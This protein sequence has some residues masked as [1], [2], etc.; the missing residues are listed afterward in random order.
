MLRRLPRAAG[1]G[2]FALWRNSRFPHTYIFNCSSNSSLGIG[3]EGWEL[4]LEDLPLSAGLGGWTG[5]SG[6]RAGER[7]QE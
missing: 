7:T 3:R 2:P 1:S 5:G 4:L 6:Q